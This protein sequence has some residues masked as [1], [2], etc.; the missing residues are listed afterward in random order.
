M[1]LFGKSTDELR[2]DRDALEALIAGRAMELGARTATVEETNSELR[3]LTTRLVRMNNAILQRT[4][5]SDLRRERTELVQS[6][7]ALDEREAA[8]GSEDPDLQARQREARAER[9]RIEWKINRLDEHL[10]QRAPEVSMKMV[11][12]FIG[13]AVLFGILLEFLK[14]AP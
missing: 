11:L 4:S 2:V 12:M 14:R 8:Q 9:M 1:S 5:L 13:A 6:L 7:D 3:P 10:A